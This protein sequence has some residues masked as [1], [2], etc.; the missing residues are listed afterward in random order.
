MR[1]NSTI[2]SLRASIIKCRKEFD[3][4]SKILPT[5]AL[6][7][8]EYT[9]EKLF[10]IVNSEIQQNKFVQRV[11]IFSE[12][13]RQDHEIS[14]REGL[15]TKAKGQTVKLRSQNS[16][17]VFS[18]GRS[19]V[20]GSKTSMEGSERPTITFPIHSELD[21]KQLAELLKHDTAQKYSEDSLTDELRGKYGCLV[22]LILCLVLNY[23]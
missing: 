14:P 6:Y 2:E 5:I 1:E 22:C 17:S 13:S 19:D 18:R 9:T 23:N 8:Q 4:N 21:Y 15:S 11:P 3:F 20:K 12:F 16:M 10:D 7:I